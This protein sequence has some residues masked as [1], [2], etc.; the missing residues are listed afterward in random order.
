MP[1]ISRAV[2][3][4]QSAAPITRASASIAIN[5]GTQAAPNAATLATMGPPT[6]AIRVPMRS[7][8]IPAITVPTNLPTANAV[9][10]CAAPPAET[11]NSRANTGMVGMMIAQAPERKVPAYSAARP[12]T[13]GLDLSESSIGSAGRVL[14][15]RRLAV[16]SFQLLKIRLH[17]IL[18]SVMGKFFEIIDQRSEISDFLRQGR[19]LIEISVV[20]Q[21]MAQL[22]F[23][24]S[25][26]VL[27]RYLTLKLA[28]IDRIRWHEIQ[29]LLF[30][31]LDRLGLEQLF[32]LGHQSIQLPRKLSLFLHRCQR[33]LQR[34]SIS[35]PLKK[36]HRGQRAERRN[37]R[38]FNF[39]GQGEILIIVKILVQDHFDPSHDPLPGETHRGDGAGI[40]KFISLP[41][42]NAIPLDLVDLLQLQFLFS[43]GEANGHADVDGGVQRQSSN[44][45]H[46]EP[47][48]RKRLALLTRA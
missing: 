34:F 13:V 40:G 18:R 9:T 17:S 43:G 30:G 6:S 7:N 26:R 36:F 11:P 10:I 19:N 31:L 2:A 24:H 46:P 48:H 20:C 41:I 3:Q 21:I 16:L 1:A 45:L 42:V 25:G 39:P 38:F 15:F 44:P 4:R 37:N 5:H 32:R 47:Q 23:Q 33:S 22:R 28:V 8:T 29:D 12:R 35:L 14:L 27:A